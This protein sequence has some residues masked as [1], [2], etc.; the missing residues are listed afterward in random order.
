MVL[1]FHLDPFLCKGFLLHLLEHKLGMC[2]RHSP[3][4][5][6]SRSDTPCSEQTRV[7]C[8]HQVNNSLVK[9]S[10]QSLANCFCENDL[11]LWFLPP[12]CVF[13]VYIIFCLHPLFSLGC[14]MES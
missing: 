7:F 5:Y 4:Y 12:A 3:P 2:L 9:I 14:T 1:A 6:P 13:E 8:G 10:Y 11:S